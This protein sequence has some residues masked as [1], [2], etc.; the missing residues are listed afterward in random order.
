MNITFNIYIYIW[1]LYYMY[2]SSISLIPKGL[3]WFLFHGTTLL[4]LLLLYTRNNIIY[5]QKHAPRLNSG[6]VDLPENI[7]VFILFNCQGLPNS[8]NWHI[9]NLPSIAINTLHETTFFN[10]LSSQFSDGSDDIG[11]TISG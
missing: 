2:W 6:L 10:V 3:L 11:T 7:Y 8:N 1:S 9:S 5:S 4:L